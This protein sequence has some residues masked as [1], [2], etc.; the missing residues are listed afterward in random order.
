MENIK[1][2][3]I[4]EN[5]PILNFN[6]EKKKIKFYYNDKEFYSYEGLMVT[7]ALSAYG[8]YNI[9]KNLNDETYQGLFCANGM[10]SQCRIIVNGEIV[11]G[12]MTPLKDGDKVYS[13]EK[14]PEL[15]LRKEKDFPDIYKIEV[16]LLII[17]AG[18]AGLSAA[19]VLSD[20]E[21][22]KVLIIDDK[23]RAG[24]KLILQTHKFFGSQEDCYAGKRGIEIAEILENKI[25][26]KKNIKLLLN[27]YFVSVFEDSLVG[28]FNGKNYILVKTKNV[29]L[30]TGAREKFLSFKGNH[31][32]GIFG[33]GAFQTLLNRDLIKCSENIF[34]V[35]SGNV[36]LIAAYH[37]LQAGIKVI[38]ICD[39][40]S[41]ASG[42]K[43]HLD[44]IKR[45]GVKI[46]FNHVPIEAKGDKRVEKILIS[47]CDNRFKPIYKNIKEF[48]IDT[49]L[50]AVGLKENNEF[51]QIFKNSGINIY[52]AGDA[53]EIAE[54]SSAMFSGKLIG[55]KFLKDIGFNITI[56]QKIY[57]KEKI[58]KSSGGKIF[59]ETHY[60]GNDLVFPNIF[61][62]QQ[63][64]CNPCTTICPV[65]AIKIDGDPIYDLPFY[66]GNCT[67]CLKCVLICPGLA[68]TL[69][70]KNKKKDDKILI[71]I[72]SEF[73]EDFI[74]LNNPQLNNSNEND[75]NNSK[76]EKYIQLTDCE[77][78][79]I[80]NGIIESIK[81]FPKEKRWIIN[82]WANTENAIKIASFKLPM[83]YNIEK[84]I[85]YYN[86]NKSKNYKINNSFEGNICICERVKEKE[87]REIIKLGITDINFIK[88]ATRL[89]MGACGGKSCSTTILSIFRELNINNNDIIYNTPRP[90][91]VEIPLKYFAGK[92]VERKFWEL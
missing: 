57:E 90:F 81:Y 37:A 87:V 80:E 17:G 14:I 29:F 25:K 18:P 71:S 67:G 85:H 55:L 89:S 73:P 2:P 49:V 56:D 38:G 77:G 63:I 91:I 75:F 65:N 10:C 41:Y 86:E 39:A 82:V 12:C 84:N 66:K 52:K 88:A 44:K 28:L 33:A 11:K 64:P 24:G 43:V 35:G 7:S 27:T 53:N 19:S 79:F 16:D 58:L 54:A 74:S 32:P 34:I 47:E 9:G 61:C 13:I 4:V 62:F 68:I 42:Y 60:E 36:G 5:H 3:S 22:I 83:L 21:D 26:N 8:I 30:T 1:E 70:N 46:F 59:E 48:D 31:L 51:E 40:A 78:N 45:Y 20:Y 69:V 15:A 6:K 72:P 92:L 23:E 76:N 50:I